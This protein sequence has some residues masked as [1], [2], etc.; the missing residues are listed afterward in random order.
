MNADSDMTLLPA[1]CLVPLVVRAYTPVVPICEHC[2]PTEYRREYRWSEAAN[3]E[4]FAGR[5]C[6]AKAGSVVDLKYRYVKRISKR[7]FLMYT[8][9]ELKV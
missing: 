4:I 2:A 1:L 9:Q 3:I 5:K 6:N 7:K 8:R